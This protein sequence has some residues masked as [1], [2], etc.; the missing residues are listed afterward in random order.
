MSYANND[1]RDL[2]SYLLR[3]F[4]PLVVKMTTLCKL[5]YKYQIKNMF[6]FA[7]ETICIIF[8]KYC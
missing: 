1:V 2:N 4:L 3:F 6:L 7:G 5:L 8:A